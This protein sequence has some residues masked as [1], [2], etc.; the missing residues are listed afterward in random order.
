MDPRNVADPWLVQVL[1]AFRTVG[2]QGKVLKDARWQALEISWDRFHGQRASQKMTPEVVDGKPCISG[3]DELCDLVAEHS[4]ESVGEVTDALAILRDR[5]FSKVASGLQAVSKYRNFEAHPRIARLK[6]ELHSAFTGSTGPSRVDSL[7]TPA[8]VRGADGAERFDIASNCELDDEEPNVEAAIETQ[9]EGEPVDTLKGGTGLR[10][11]SFPAAA[12][13]GAA[14][15]KTDIGLVV[16]KMKWADISS[17]SEACHGVT[18]YCAAWSTAA[19]RAE[20]KLAKLLH[21]ACGQQQGAPSSGGLIWSPKQ[22]FVVA[23]AKMNDDAEQVNDAGAKDADAGSIVMTEKRATLALDEMH[24]CFK[25]SYGDG[26]VGFEKQLTNGKTEVVAQ[27]FSRLAPGR[28][29][30]KAALAEANRVFAKHGLREDIDFSFFGEF[31]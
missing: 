20:I 9:C 2:Y 16:N 11:S 25:R 8:S 10:P 5:G 15:V 17:D 23:D 29:V 18:D 31:L 24:V 13:T 7:G 6:R 19:S 22:F 28:V 4:G 3:L 30:W 12:A 14:D 1:A 27:F 26:F 21:E